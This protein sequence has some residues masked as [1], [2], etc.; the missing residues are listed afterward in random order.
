MIFDDFIWL[1][2]ALIHGATSSA[3]TVFLVGMNTYA[4]LPYFGQGVSAPLWAVAFAGGVIASL[5]SDA[6]H[7]YVKDEIHIKQ[8]AQD[9]ASLFL[10]AVLSGLFFYGSFYIT[11]PDLA[12]DIGYVKSFAVGAGSE[13]AASFIANMI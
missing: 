4:R 6:V 8:K 3:G 5:A 12:N 11:G 1:P 2:K 13:I 9:E 10:G 7:N